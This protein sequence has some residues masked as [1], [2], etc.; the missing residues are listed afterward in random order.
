MSFLLTIDTYWVIFRFRVREVRCCCNH[1]DGEDDKEKKRAELVHCSS[2][3]EDVRRFGHISSIEALI[4]CD[5]LL[6]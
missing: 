5:E 4:R 6:K 3:V 2:D 1:Q